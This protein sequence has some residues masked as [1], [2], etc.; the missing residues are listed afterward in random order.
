MAVL[1]LLTPAPVAAVEINR[2]VLRVNDEIATLADYRQRRDDRLRAIAQ[3]DVPEERRQ[4]LAA[5]AG[6]D[7]LQ[8]IF[9]ELLVLSRAGQLG[10]SVSD[11]QVDPAI[12]QMKQ[13]FGI[14]TE[15]QF[16]AALQSSGLTVEALQDQVRRNLLVREVMGLEVQSRI[17]VDEESLRRYYSEH[18]EEF[19]IP[20][21]VELREV[22][23]L[24]SSGLPLEEMVEIAVA[25]RR[26]LVAGR[27]LQEAIAKYD[28]QGL[29]SDPIELG[30]VNDAD[31]D[32]SLAAAVA[33]LQAGEFSDPVA[34]RGGVHVVEMVARREAGTRSFQEVAP[35]LEARERERRFEEEMQ[36]YVT[37]LAETAYVMAEPP[38]DAAGFK[39]R[40]PGAGDE[41]VPGT[42]AESAAAIAEPS[43]AEEAIEGEDAEAPASPAIDVTFT[44]ERDDLRPAPPEPPPD[45]RPVPPEE[46]EAEEPPP[47]T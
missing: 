27:T 20:A 38:A 19:E 17:Q 40:V 33:D 46:D 22:V 24:E 9:E 28:G 5:T 32:P 39:P 36:E 41:A 16:Q 14:E 35:A 30:W 12:E 15:A 31:L 43:S 8:E 21:Q 44:P 37:E 18:P 42:L 11:D 13:G 45:M 1:A 26:E 34:A 4:E 23:V 47:G 25:I 7:T 2:I 10:I 6:E 29:V 3:A